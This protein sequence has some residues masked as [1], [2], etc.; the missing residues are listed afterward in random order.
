[1][2]NRTMMTRFKRDICFWKDDNWRLD[3][4]SHCVENDA[5]CLCN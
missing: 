5:G 4:A 1:M 2:A 3:E